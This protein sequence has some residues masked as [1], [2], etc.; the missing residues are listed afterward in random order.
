MTSNRTP[1]PDSRRRPGLRRRPVL[2]LEAGHDHPTRSTRPWTSSPPAGE[3]ITELETREAGHFAEL[4]RAARPAGRHGHRDQP[5]PGRGHRRAWPGST[6]STGRSPSSPGGARTGDEDAGYQPRPAPAWWTARRRRT[7]VAP[8]GIAGLGRARLP[9]RLRPP[10]RPRRLLGRARPV[11]VRAST[12][13]ASCGPRSTSSPPAAPACCPP[14]PSTRPASCPPSPPSWP[15]ETTGCGHHRR[16]PTRGTPMTNQVLRQA[17]AYAGR[18]W[19]VF[20][21]QPGQK[22]PATRARLPRRHHRP[23]PDQRV[24]RPPPRP[25]PRHRH[26]R[27]R[28]DVLD[29]DHRGPAGSGFPALARLST[30]RAARRRRRPVRTPS[31]GCTST[32]P[33][34]ASAAATCPPATSTSSPRA[35]TSSPALPDR[36]P[37]YEHVNALAR[38]GGSTG[39]PPPLAPAPA[40]SGRDS[41]GRHGDGDRQALARWVAAQREGNRNAGLYWAANRALETSHAADLSPLAAAARQA[42]LTEPEITRTLES[43]RRSTPSSQPRT[44]PV[45]RPKEQADMTDSPRQPS[46]SHQ[47]PAARRRPRRPRTRRPAARRRRHLPLHRGRRRPRARHR[48][49][50]RRRPP[51]PHPGD[52]QGT[53]KVHRRPFPAPVWTPAAPGYGCAPCMSWAT[54]R[55]ASPA[56]SASAR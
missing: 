1:F 52:N 31:G 19:P 29:I 18:G 32:S 28:P 14:R 43:A 27:P 11:P 16:Q 10:R 54:A 25:Q 37:P 24:V 48:P 55:P 40:P 36:R 4:Q 23:G 7:A 20:P 51:R 45:P 34:P 17:L 50:P 33:D 26:R 9:P 2:P 8:G 22:T 38:H 35:A 30:G 56:P 49:R 12:S 15:T 6:P 13:P 46:T 53:A 39:T 5:R 3:R 21:C 44:S 41:P 47:S 42:G